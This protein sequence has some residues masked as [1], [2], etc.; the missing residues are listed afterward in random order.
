MSEEIALGSSG[1]LDDASNVP[2]RDDDADNVQNPEAR[3][4]PHAREWFRIFGADASPHTPMPLDRDEHKEKEDQDLKD[5]AGQRDVLAKVFFALVVRLGIAQDAG[6]DGL[7]EEAEYVAQ[8]EYLGEPFDSDRRE[9]GAAGGPHQPAEG[10][11][12]C[13]SE[14][15]GCDE[16]EDGLRSVEP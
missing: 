9:E 12:Y 3:F 16:D 11:V 1:E 10:H 5:E 15:G 8:D 4:P 13:C 7:D 14:E 6:A 2:H